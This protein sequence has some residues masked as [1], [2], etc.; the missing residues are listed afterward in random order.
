MHLLSSEVKTG[1]APGPG[2]VV[3]GL[4]RILV[5]LSFTIHGLSGLFA[6]PVAPHG[7]H[8]AAVGSW[9]SWWASV[10]QLVAGGLV[11]LGLGTRIAALLCSGSMAYAFL[12]VHLKSDGILPIQN[13]GEAAAMFCWSFFLIAILGPGAFAMDALLPRRATRGAAA[14]PAHARG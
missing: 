5:G 9:P 13:G 6:W 10:I 7:G 8:V 3:L 1:P 4:F 14:D 11:T 2:A 12:F